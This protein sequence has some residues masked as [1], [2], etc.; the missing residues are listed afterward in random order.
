MIIDAHTHIFSPNVCHMRERYCARDGWFNELYQDARARMSTAEDLITAMDLD[1][2]DRSVVCGFAWSDQALCREQN[3]YIIDSVRRYPDRLI[4]MAVV[5]PRAGQDAVHELE[6]CLK[7]GL[8]GL[9]ELFPDGQGF[10]L[11]EV[12]T[13]EPLAELLIKYNWPLLTHTSEPVGHQYQGKGR[14][15]P[16]HVITLAQSFPELRIVCGHWGGGLPFY[17]LM[18]EVA[19]ALQHVYYDTAASPYL[20]RWR[21][22]SVA[23]QM[24]GGGKV[25][26]GSDYPLI[27]AR[28]YLKH[29][30]QLSIEEQDR[31]AI[32][33]K[34][35]V[36][37]WMPEGK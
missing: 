9:G 37:L 20:Y 32:V 28:T 26:F 29:L 34:N 27:R 13:L 22:F 7:A 24:V 15:L 16:Q 6:R 21:I 36:K 33:G 1:G 17:E 25:L 14:T 23:T 12:E 8:R 5:Q 10:S 4:G 11:E 30:E 19:Q 35:A 31:Q 2:V 18:P 3:D